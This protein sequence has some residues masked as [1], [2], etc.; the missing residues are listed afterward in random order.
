MAIEEIW[1]G[2]RG[3]EGEGK[4]KAGQKEEK[5]RILK[6]KGV[7]RKLDDKWLKTVREKRKLMWIKEEPRLPGDTVKGGRINYLYMVLIPLGGR[8][9][10]H[11]RCLDSHLPL[12]SS[13]PSQTPSQSTSNLLQPRSNLWICQTQGLQNIRL[14][15]TNKNPDLVLFRAWKGNLQDRIV[16]NE[17][18][19]QWHRTYLNEI[20]IR[21][22]LTRRIDIMSNKLPQHFRILVENSQSSRVFSVNVEREAQTFDTSVLREGGRNKTTLTPRFHISCLQVHVNS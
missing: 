22:H 12:P 17:L 16:W 15:C 7:P 8:R 20:F 14:F 6:C 18:R 2:T 1:Q 4:S 19:I 21:W 5:N 3:K 9:K 10:P 13:P 11:L